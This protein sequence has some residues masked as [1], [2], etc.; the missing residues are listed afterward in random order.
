MEDYPLA[1][2]AI[3][4]P[5]IVLSGLLEEPANVQLPSPLNNGP[6]TAP[7]PAVGG[8]RAAEVLRAFMAFDVNL[9]EKDAAKFRLLSSSRVYISSSSDRANHAAVL[10]AD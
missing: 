8:D 1:Y 7:G 10:I 5:L 4:R 3:A 2:A 6:A 9:N